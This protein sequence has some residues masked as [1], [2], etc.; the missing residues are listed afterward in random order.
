MYYPVLKLCL[1]LM[2]ACLE[3]MPSELDSLTC[4]LILHIDRLTAVSRINVVCALLAVYFCV[5]ALM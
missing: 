1:A 4:L 3:V 5:C 2:F